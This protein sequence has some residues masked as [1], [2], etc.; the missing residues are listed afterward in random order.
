MMVN[1]VGAESMLINVVVNWF[2]ELERLL[3]Y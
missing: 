2:D 1:G 3:P